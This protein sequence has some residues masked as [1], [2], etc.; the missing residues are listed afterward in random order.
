M[1]ISVRTLGQATFSQVCPA[2][3]ETHPQLRTGREKGPLLPSLLPYSI[4][5]SSEGPC[6]F[7]DCSVADIPWG[8]PPSRKVASPARGTYQN[9]GCYREKISFDEP[10]LIEVVNGIQVFL[11]GN[12]HTDTHRHAGCQEQGGEQ[13]S[14]PR[15]SGRGVTVNYHGAVAGTKESATIILAQVDRIKSSHSLHQA[16][17]AS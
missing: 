1:A 14:P 9:R 3:C 8:T 16:A 5:S 7:P 11:P 4:S 6:P 2:D 17:W 10:L 12:T 15:I 13:T